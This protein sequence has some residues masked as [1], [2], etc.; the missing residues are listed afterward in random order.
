M[1]SREPLG[2]HRVWRVIQATVAL[3]VMASACILSSAAHAE[4]GTRPFGGTTDDPSAISLPRNKPAFIVQKFRQFEHTSNFATGGVGLRNQITGGV[5]INGVVGSVQ[6]AYLYWA[7]IAN[8]T[9]PA[10]SKALL[11]R[12]LSNPP[13]DYVTVFGTEVGSG[14]SPCWGG[15]PIKVFR[16]PV[17]L[18]VATGNGFY[19]VRILPPGAG[20]TTGGDPWKSPVVYPLWEGASLVII[21]TGS[22]PN[23]F[24]PPVVTLFDN[25][26]SGNT[27]ASFP[28]P[29]PGIKYTLVVPGSP[30]NSEPLTI[31]FIGADGQNGSVLD[32]FNTR[33]FK[34]ILSVSDESTII[35]QQPVAGPGSPATDSD[36]NGSS[37]FPLPQLWDDMRHNNTFQGTSGPPFV[38]G[39]FNIVVASKSNKLSSDCLTPVANIVSWHID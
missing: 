13:G 32:I 21:G 16:A 31:A 7:V 30:R 27:F 33:D 24:G 2:K 26:L 3:S 34:E 9:L 39:F 12:R 25:G 35:N 8:G 37:G 18:N 1:N 17:P 14:L 6:A 28:G 10:F 36:W 20:A 15:G 19:Q 5:V 23:T 29:T 22:E 4:N 38:E 11:I